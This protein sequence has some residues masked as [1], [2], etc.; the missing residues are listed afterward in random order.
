MTHPLLWRL[1]PYRLCPVLLPILHCFL[2]MSTVGMG[3]FCAW[4]AF[5]IFLFFNFHTSVKYEYLSYRSSVH[6]Y[7]LVI[8][9][10]RRDFR[11]THAVIFNMSCK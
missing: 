8:R 3:N 11:Q 7:A 10:C 2:F 4:I 9:S 1:S 5:F 6:H